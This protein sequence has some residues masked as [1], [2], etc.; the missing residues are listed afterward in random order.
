[1]TLSNQPTTNTLPYENILDAYFVKYHG[2]Q[3]YSQDF[4]LIPQSDTS[5][6]EDQRINYKCT[7][8]EYNTLDIMNPTIVFDKEG[9]TVQQIW[10]RTNWTLIGIGLRYYARVNQSEDHQS[11]FGRLVLGI[12]YRSRGSTYSNDRAVNDS[13]LPDTFVGRNMRNGMNFLHS[14]FFMHPDTDP[15]PDYYGL[16]FFNNAWSSEYKILYD[17]TFNCCVAGSCVYNKQ[18][19]IPIEQKCQF[20][21]DYVSE[22]GN[23]YKYLGCRNSPFIAWLGPWSH[24]A[25]TGGPD[26]CL[27][28]MVSTRCY[29]IKNQ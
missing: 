12:D 6:E 28:L 1:M 8:N 17:D 26:K 21:W 29:Y 23:V 15:L 22:A 2:R 18:V 3:I 5:A 13:L 10:S 25:L 4:E 20:G 27:E 7:N 11:T 24:D 16:T 9:E 19:F 14:T